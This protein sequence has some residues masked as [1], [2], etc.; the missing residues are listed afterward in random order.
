MT[1]HC[2][3]CSSELA[4][5]RSPG[6]K[7]ESNWNFNRRQFCNPNCHNAWRLQQSVQLCSGKRCKVCHAP[8]ERKTYPNGSIDSPAQ[9]ARRRHCSQKCRTV[10]QKREARRRQRAWRR[11]TQDYASL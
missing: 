1:R 6:G 11:L 8:I 7:L 4:R 2:K 3:T 10:T 9:I 5:H